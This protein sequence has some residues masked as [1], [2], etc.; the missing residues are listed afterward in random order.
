MFAAEFAGLTELAGANAVRVPTPLLADATASDAFLAIEWLDL[1]A[2][3]AAMHHRLGTQLALLH[4]HQGAQF[5][6]HRDNTI[7]AT[8][9][10]NAASLDWVSF[11]REQRLQHQLR[12]AARNG[13]SG[14]L[15]EQ[16]TWLC[17]R[18]EKLFAGYQPLP[19]LLHGDL[20]GGN[21]S[22]CSNEPVIYDPAVHYGDRETD[23]AMTRLFGGFSAD[24]YAAY[25]ECWPL[26]D[27]A[28]ARIALYQLYHVLNHLNLFGGGYLA[29]AEALL[30][31]LRCSIG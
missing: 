27:G 4:R 1:S 11:Y 17:D 3:S 16:G 14:R 31:Q 6:W 10:P 28:A 2:P 8:P 5:G 21:W 9:Q 25:D 20:W 29:Q 18:L 23:L 12:L 15:Q 24:F 30:G 26:A 19:S 13:Y 7:G 22:A